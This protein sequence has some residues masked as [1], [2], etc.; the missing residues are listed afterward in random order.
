[1]LTENEKVSIL[2]DKLLHQSNNYSDVM[3]T[4]IY[5]YFFDLE[6]GNIAEFLNKFST[7]ENIES[8]IDFLVSKMILHENEEGLFSIIE[9]YQ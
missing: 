5:S 6:N 7:K 8:H 9:E 4:E 3:K 2:K 1:M